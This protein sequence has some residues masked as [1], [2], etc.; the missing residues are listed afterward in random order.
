MSEYRE[1]ALLLESFMDNFLPI[2]WTN[3]PE[4]LESIRV[5]NEDEETVPAL[6]RF[7]HWD[8]L[9]RDSHPEAMQDLYGKL[10]FERDGEAHVD[11]A[12]GTD[13]TFAVHVIRFVFCH[14]LS[15]DEKKSF[16]ARALCIQLLDDMEEAMI[17][18][19]GR[20]TPPPHQER[21]SRG[22]P[23]PQKIQIHSLL[24]RL[25]DLTRCD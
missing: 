11:S 18:A 4:E 21:R 3:R 13:W 22:T 25:R 17:K 19:D 12:S 15:S 20:R 23:E 9:M 6:D 8:S 2:L 1:C 5:W 14:L 16:E 24:T 7:D 10:K